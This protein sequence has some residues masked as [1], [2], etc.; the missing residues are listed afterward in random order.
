M[1]NVNSST[2]YPFTNNDNNEEKWCEEYTFTE[3]IVHSD[4]SSNNSNNNSNA[5][6]KGILKKPKNDINEQDIMLCVKSFAFLMLLSI[7]V[8]FIVC[9]LYYAYNDTSCVTI[10]PRQFSINLKMY[11]A[12]DGI[13]GA[14]ALF[15][16]IFAACCIKEEPNS[17]NNFCL[18]MFG[19]ITTAFGIAWTI[20]GAIIFWKLIDNRECDRAVY[21]YISAQLII[22]FICYSLRIYSNNK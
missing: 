16:I 3:I 20:I 4:N 14:I 11:L 1:S 17:S 22:K 18:N 10:N 6:I 2:I 12:L 9:N 19:N 7:T 8:P 5:N 15:I 21:N 13:V